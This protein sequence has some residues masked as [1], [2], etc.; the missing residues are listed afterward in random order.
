MGMRSEPLVCLPAMEL[1]ANRLSGLM[2]P[3]QSM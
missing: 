1:A 3:T 2:A